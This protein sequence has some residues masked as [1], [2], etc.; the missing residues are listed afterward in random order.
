MGYT[1]QDIRNI[2]L[3][4][5]AG[6]GKTL[7]LEALLLQAGVIRT[8]GSLQRG[9]TVSDFDPQE[10]RLQHSIDTALCTFDC[11]RTHFTLIDTPGYPDFLGRTY[12]VL[13]AVEAAAVV[14]SATAGVDTVS[15]RLMDF[16]HDR[17]LCRLVIIN[18]I[19]SK[20]AHPEAVL[21]AV[22]ATF[23]AECL[24]LNLPCQG[25]RSVVDCFFQPPEEP[26][27]F[28]S[29]ATAHTQI[30]DQ[31]VEVDEELM[32]LYLEQGEELSPT[33]LHDPF[34]KALREGHLVPVCFVSAETGAGI[35]ELL[36]IFVRLMPNPCEGN[37]PPFLKGPEPDAIRVPVAPDPENHVIA[38]VFKVSVD[39]YVGK[40]GIFRVHQGT[41]RPG[42]QLFVGDARKPFRIAHLYRILG[43]DT[44]EVPHGIPGDVCAVSK[45]DELHFDAVLHD[46]HDED[47]YHLKSIDFP[48]A[49]HGLAIEPERRGDE[50]RLA[51][52]LHKITAEDPCVRIENHASLNETV[53]YGMG[54]FHLRVLLERMTERYGVHIKTHPPSIPYRETITRQAEGH[55]RHKKQTGGA[56]QFGEVYLRVEAL[57]RG[58][59]FEFVDE[60]VGGAIPGQFI[61]AVEKGVRQVLTEGAVAGFPLQDIRVTVFDGKHHAVDSKEVAF[62]SAGRKA[63]LAAIQKAHPIVLEPVVRMEITA[64][65]TAIGDITGDLA[66]KRARINGNDARP[67][68]R[69]AVT[70]LVPLAEIVE[71]QSRLKSLTGGT[72]AFT[73][74]LSHYDPV[75]AR[76]Q[77]EL[78]QAWR[79]R[80]EEA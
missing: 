48:P 14:I 67:G 65:A 52:A 80:A 11:G 78:V 7:L 45:V 25:G 60:V 33:Q 79:P 2:A 32:S 70:A 20:D 53:L 30:I 21:D 75:P 26:A 47:Q 71:Y 35:A 24:P 1:T 23:G 40:L 16:A 17:G 3:V 69:A 74:E 46:S 8:K 19:D 76:K 50:Q 77:Q 63:F 55:C 72:G 68:Q 43:K 12:S 51:D 59:G 27:D 31:V 39:P 62:V 18:K 29:V 42:S 34:E 56:G 36:D 41:A 28:S 61:P 73:M 9:N 54:E 13:E 5:P 66:T 57:E 22:R 37:S 4:G 58:R 15:E 6:A 10:K 64:P 38:H 44:S 49:M